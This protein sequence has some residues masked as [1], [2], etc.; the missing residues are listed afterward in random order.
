MLPAKRDSGALSTI[1]IRR[2]N[3]TPVPLPIR[4]KLVS[5]CRRSR[6]SSKRREV[7]KVM[8]AQESHH[9]TAVTAHAEKVDESELLV[10]TPGEKQNGD[11][12]K[13]YQ[14]ERI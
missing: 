9:K 13:Q 3:A 14:N 2:Y 12:F 4:A 7:V 11:V 5:T 8:K 1:T 10:V 6:Q